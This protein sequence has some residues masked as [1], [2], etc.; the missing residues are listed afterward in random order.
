MD[1]DKLL[2]PVKPVANENEKTKEGQQELLG[3]SKKKETFP[4]KTFPK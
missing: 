2:L 4:K 1:H 3:Q